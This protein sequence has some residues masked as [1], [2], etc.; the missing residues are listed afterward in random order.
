M[1]EGETKTLVELRSVSV[2]HQSVELVQERRDG[3]TNL[4][5]S[6]SR[7]EMQLKVC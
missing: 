5:S 4:P 7:L 6:I 2:Y 3:V 1:R